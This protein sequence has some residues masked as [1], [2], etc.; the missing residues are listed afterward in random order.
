L[1]PTEKPAE[2]PVTPAKP[3][4]PPKKHYVR[5]KDLLP[6]IIDC[7]EKGIVSD[8]LGRMLLL[9]VE[10]YARKYNWA[11]YTFRDDMKGHAMV[12]LSNAALK[13]D[14]ARSNNPFAY[15]T[16]VAKNAFIQIIKQ[17]RK[18]RDIK[19]LHIVEG[20]EG[21]P[22]WTFQDAYKAEMDAQKADRETSEQ[23]Q[24]EYDG[25]TETAASEAPKLELE[26]GPAEGEE[27]LKPKEEK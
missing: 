13:F 14:P 3:A 1:I 18:Q 20:G 5:N 26:S 21:L 24:S 27:F 10:N 2:T 8:K 23:A 4:T 17:E 22:S 19:D 7:R 25:T 9:I 15:Y 16:Q 11:N 6:E 12:H